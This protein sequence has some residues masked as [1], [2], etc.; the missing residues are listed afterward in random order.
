VKL[1]HTSIENGIPCRIVPSLFEAS[2]RHAKLAG[3]AALP[4]VDMSVDVVLP[5][6]QAT[7]C[8]C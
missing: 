7:S 4:V 3:L 2:Y 5:R 8:S 1:L 6:F